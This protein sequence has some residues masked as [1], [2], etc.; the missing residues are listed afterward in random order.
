MPESGVQTAE[1]ARKIKASL[2]P[3]GYG[4]LPFENRSQSMLQ[5]AR[6]TAWPDRILRNIERG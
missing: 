5:K 6:S 2:T 4:T 1:K 3:E